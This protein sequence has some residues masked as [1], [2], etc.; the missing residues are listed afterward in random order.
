MLTIVGI[1]EEKGPQ[2]F[3]IDP[4]GFSMG[5]K[6]IATGAKEQEAINHLE[7]LHKKWKENYTLDEAIQT[8]ISTLSSVIGA[9]FKASELEVGFASI[10][11]PYF[12]KLA[13][14]DIEKHLN[15]IADSN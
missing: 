2:V 5:Y 8:A 9:D 3:K 6:A 12:R 14:S 4:A 1:D 7:K 10:D 11:R 15:D 13:I